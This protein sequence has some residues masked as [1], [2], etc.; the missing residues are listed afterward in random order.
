M[1]EVMARET[2]HRWHDLDAVRALALL[3]GV[4]L[5]ATMSFIEPQIWV[6]K[7]ISHDPGLGIMFYVIHMFRMITFFVLAGFFA[8]MLMQKRG[9]GG[10]VANRLKRVALPLV[11][12][13][14]LI[15]ASI[16][17][18]V[19]FANMPAPGSAAASAPPPPPPGLTAQTFPLTHLWF[20]YMLLILYAGA[21]LLKVVTDVLHIGGI[22][23]KMADSAM[24]LLVRTD[25]VSAVLIAP[26]A[27]A[28]W[29]NP[30]W[31]MW[32]GVATPDTGLVPNVMALASYI[33]AFGFG[34]LLHRRS[35][36]IAHL[37][38]RWWLYLFSAAIATWWC[39]TIVGVQPAVVPV[40]GHDHP[41]YILVYA[42]GAWSWT[43][44]L[45][46]AAH[47]FLKVENPVIRYLSDASY[48]VYII[49]IPV[50]MTLQYL[51]KDIVWPAEA[52]FAV[53]FLATMMIALLTYQIVV[54]YSFIG[55][56]LN[57]RR[58][59]TQA[60]SQ[61]VLA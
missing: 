48:W 35:D 58:R 9:L 61:E 44:G 41:I 33:T 49:H 7:D 16:V 57:G 53:V 2:G 23:G 3:L 26:M 37:A 21:V 1:A 34:W 60:L 45:I 59:K 27:L 55:A 46:G 4:K 10:F 19:I 38:G 14:P 28:L 11:V 56:I 40:N 51:V 6:V 36:L 54:R 31:M 20:L 8:R 50:L 5:H 30:Q 47:A 52:K 29:S 32:F 42:L 18:I 24:G 39:L 13:W 15:F 12:F 22:L 25:L 43:L 17:A